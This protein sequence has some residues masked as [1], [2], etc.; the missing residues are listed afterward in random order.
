MTGKWKVFEKGDF[1]TLWINKNKKLAISFRD[2]KKYGIASDLNYPY[3]VELLKYGKNY[4][5]T[6]ILES[7]TFRTEK[8]AMKYAEK[9]K[10]AV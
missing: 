8:D 5:V 1:G 3:D 10:K 6:D 7:K 9:L 2:W 4:V